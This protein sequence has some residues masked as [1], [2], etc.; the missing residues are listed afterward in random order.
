[1]ASPK[2]HHEPLAL[3]PGPHTPAQLTAMLNELASLYQ[4]MGGKGESPA[5]PQPPPVA[6]VEPIVRAVQPQL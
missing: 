3:Y 2:A 6:D 4:E 5:E 1:M